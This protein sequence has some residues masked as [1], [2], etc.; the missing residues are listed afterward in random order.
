MRLIRRFPLLACLAAIVAFADLPGQVG[1]IS[2]PANV[3][4]NQDDSGNPN[5]ET[6]LAADPNDPLHLVAVWWEVTLSLPEETHKRMHY[7]WT[8]DG[9]RTWQSRPLETGDDQLNTD[10]A[11]VADRQGNFYLETLQAPRVGP[12]STLE[13]RRI[14]IFKSTDGG[15]SFFHT[16]DVAIDTLIDKPFLAVDPD[17][18]ALYLVWTDIGPRAPV[19]EFQ[20]HFAAS[21]DRGASFTPPRPITSRSSYGSMA[22][23]TVG[24][25]GEVYVIWGGAFNGRIWFD[26]SLDGGKTWLKQDVLV[27]AMNRGDMRAF[28]P[29]ILPA[30]AVDRSNGAHR[31]RIYA[32]WAAGFQ[33]VGFPGEIDIML[34]WSDDR[35]DHWSNPVRVNDDAAGNLAE[36]FLPWV[37]VDDR[38]HVH[39]TFL[40]NRLGPGRSMMAEYMATS[41]DGGVTFGPNIRVSD[42]PSRALRFIGDYNQP[43]A[44]GNRL[45]AIWADGRL[46]VHNIFT[47]SVDLDD[48]DEDGILNDGDRNGQYADHRC[49]GGVVSL[50][51]DNCP[52]T[53]NAGQA[54]TDGD[55]VG[56]ACDNCPLERNTNQSDLDRN[57]VG[58]VCEEVS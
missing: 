48:F 43:V 41:T 14:G 53:P 7:G 33:Y 52:G 10:P 17:T 44:A 56:D 40:D 36:Q 47:Q 50:C 30:I 35:G 49:A 2:W 8:R 11:V 32:V 4:V 57:G 31:G 13:G 23:P 58:D 3:R 16:T 6:S 12:T 29:Y 22:V 25:A 54:D 39:V 27:T 46:G 15:E 42:T 20:V 1:E 26:R 38:G 18:D 9:G 51:D 37:V 24:L 55:L 45:H 34:A 19:N 5:A 21:L 28:F